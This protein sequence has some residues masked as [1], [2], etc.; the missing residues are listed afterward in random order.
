MRQVTRVLEKR[1]CDIGDPCH[2]HFLNTGRGLVVAARHQQG[3]Y[4]DLVKP[5]PYVPI[6]KV[7]DNE[8]LAR[9]V[10][11][12]I[13]GGIL[14]DLRETTGQAF[15]PGNP[16]QVALVVDPT[17]GGI[18]GMVCGSRSLMGAQSLLDLGRK[19]RSELVGLFH[20]QGE[21]GH[22]VADHETLEPARVLERVLHR[23]HAT[24]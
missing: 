7:P 3:R 21:R 24:A 17:C 18:V 20:P 13:H 16:A 1:P 9:P 4:V 23:Q 5:V 10:H 11:G 2:H 14:L 8:E 12:E 15:W 6:L 19:L 22:R